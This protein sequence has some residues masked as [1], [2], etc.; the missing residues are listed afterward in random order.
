MANATDLPD[1]VCVTAVLPAFAPPL[2]GA[3]GPVSEALI[4]ALRRDPRMSSKSFED[5]PLVDDPLYGEDAPLALYTLYELHYRGF[6]GVDDEWE[7]DANTLRLRTRLE[8]AFLSRLE[9]V[10]AIEFGVDRTAPRDVADELRSLADAGGPSL[11]TFLATQGTLRQL[12][13]FAIHRSLYSLKEADP[14]S[15]AIPRL[16]GATKAALITIQTDEYGSGRER[17]MH[18]A[19]FGDA[20]EALGLDARYGAYLDV[21]PGEILSTVNLMSFFGLHRRWRGAIVGHL[22]LFEM[23]SVVPMGRYIEALE[24]IGVADATPFYA[25]HVVADEWHQ[26]IALDD[27]IGS[28]VIDEPQLADDIVFGARALDHLERGFTRR[29][30]RAWA[31]DGTSLYADFSPELGPRS[32]NETTS[33]DRTVDAARAQA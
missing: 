5:L 26:T 21:V 19:L 32:T 2:P 6:D 8:I 4:A 14:H 1:H 17:E 13:E 29:L 33:R 11:S 15:W 10:V 9:D 22:A 16:R 23:C 28:L 7:W 18:S 31:C 24:R 27:M 3:R 25:A 12:R 30:L 20:L